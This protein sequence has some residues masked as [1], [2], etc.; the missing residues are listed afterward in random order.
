GQCHGFVPD[1]GAL[2]GRSVDMSDFAEMLSIWAERLVIDKTGVQGLFDIKMPR[3]GPNNP[4]PAGDRKNLDIGRGGAGV[5]IRQVP[6]L[7]TVFTALEQIGLKLESTKG[8]VDVL[9]IDSVERPS[10][11]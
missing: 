11:N 8:P 9:V 2:T 10:E 5:E 6:E 7:P 4:G 1:N 3:L